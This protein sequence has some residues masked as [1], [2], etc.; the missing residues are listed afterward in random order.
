MQQINPTVR[1]VLT[2][3][4]VP[5]TAT[6][7]SSHVLLATT[8]S[9]SVLRAVAGSLAERFADVDYFPSYEVVMSHPSRGIY[10]EQNMRSVT[11][12]GVEAVMAYFFREHAPQTVATAPPASPE[13][14]NSICEEILLDAFAK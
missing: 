13:S 14:Y 5:L 3:S 10:F 9:K 6:A 2:V 4:P 8:Y 11:P 7:T 1:F 12:A